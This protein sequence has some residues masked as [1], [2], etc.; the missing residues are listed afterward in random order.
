MDKRYQ[1]NDIQSISIGHSGEL[2]ISVGQD[3]Y[4]QL[5]GQE[6]K[7]KQKIT[8]TK[9]LRDESNHFYFGILAYAV[10]ITFGDEKEHLWQSFEGVPVRITY[11]LIYNEVRNDRGK[12]VSDSS[13][14]EEEEETT[15]WN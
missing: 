9:I 15:G 4:V 6:N 14:E 7:G 3:L 8:V 13:D 12:G 5:K 2:K 10:Y 11:N 1:D